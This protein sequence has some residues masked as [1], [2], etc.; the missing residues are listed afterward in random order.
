MRSLHTETREQPLLAATREK[1]VQQ[2]PPST[3]KNKELT[4]KKRPSLSNT[5]QLPVTGRQRLAVLSPLMSNCS[6]Y[7]WLF[8]VISRTLPTLL[9]RIDSSG[10]TS[11]TKAQTVQDSQSKIDQQ[12]LVLPSLSRAGH[13]R[14]W[15]S[16]GQVWTMGVGEISLETEA[17]ATEPGFLWAEQIP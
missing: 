16:F 9:V 10:P 13:R 14:V 7:S 1:P 8:S 15:G 11:R 4:N 2:R 17:E 6:G 3:G 5:T 12:K